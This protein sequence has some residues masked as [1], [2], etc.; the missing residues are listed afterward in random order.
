M[1]NIKYVHTE[2]KKIYVGLIEGENF[3]NTYWN[4]GV[5]SYLE[6]EYKYPITTIGIDKGDDID[7]FDYI[8]LGDYLKNGSTATAIELK[9]ENYDKIYNIL[10][11]LN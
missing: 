10:H 2:Y 1:N 11:E 4:G 7:F 6:N 5:D 8:Q 9:P 3:V